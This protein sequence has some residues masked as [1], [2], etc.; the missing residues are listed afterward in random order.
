MI[1]TKLCRIVAFLVVGF[2]LMRLG[3]GILLATTYEPGTDL[4]LFIGRR[5]TGQVIDQGVYAI[6]AG[7]V[8]G[9]LTDISRAV[10][11]SKQA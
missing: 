8:L 4:S 3:M 10:Q 9:T 6:V 2:G 5:T 7:I 1:F 11:S